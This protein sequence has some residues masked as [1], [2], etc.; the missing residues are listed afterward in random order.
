M[1][2]CDTAGMSEPNQPSERRRSLRVVEG[3][4]DIVVRGSDRHVSG[5]VQGTCILCGQRRALLLGHIVPKWAFRAMK[6]EGGVIGDFPSL[7]VSTREQ[8][9]NKHYLLCQSCEQHLGRYERYLAELSRGTAASMQGIGVTAADGCVSG[10]DPERV[11]GAVA[12]IALKAH[13]CPSPPFTDF[14]VPPRVLESVHASAAT[15]DG[16]N[17]KIAANRW[18][19][20]LPNVDPKAML[21]ARVVGEDEGGA[22]EV[23]MGGWSWYLSWGHGDLHRLSLIVNRPW[24]VTTADVT[25]SLGWHRGDPNAEGIGLSNAEWRHLA[26][27]LGKG[28]SARLVPGRNEACLC[29][30]GQ[31]FK[32]CCAP[33]WGSAVEH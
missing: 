17:L 30:S 20:L 6:Q 11:E 28:S 21:F 7:G 12:G 5:G 18:V 19:S 1:P 23:M 31:K 2:R 8:D 29:G 27:R 13:H 4:H 16:A 32:R 24:R 14:T 3:D 9:G 26:S 22:L 33:L 25:L 15:P 10:L